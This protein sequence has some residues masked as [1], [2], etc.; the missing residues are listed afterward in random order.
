MLEQSVR[1]ALIFLA[2]A[3]SVAFTIRQNRTSL[4]KIVILRF[5]LPFALFLSLV[6]PITYQSVA[7]SFRRFRRKLPASPVAR[8]AAVFGIPASLGFTA[9]QLYRTPLA[10]VAG[11]LA[12]MPVMLWHF[13]VRISKLACP[14]TLAS[15]IRACAAFLIGI[16]LATGFVVG[17]N[18][19]V[20]R[21]MINAHAVAYKESPLDKSLPWHAPAPLPVA[22]ANP[23][24]KRSAL[25][26]QPTSRETASAPM[27]APSALFDL[28]DATLNPVQPATTTSR[29]GAR[30]FVNPEDDQFLADLG[31]N[32]QPW[33]KQ[34]SRPEGQS[35]FDFLIVPD[36]ASPYVGFV[37]LNSRSPATR[38]LGVG[39]LINSRI[40][41]AESFDITNDANP[42]V[43]PHDYLLNSEGTLLLHINGLAVEMISTA[44][45]RKDNFPLTVPD[46]APGDK[47]LPQLAGMTRDHG[48]LVRWSS[49]TATEQIV[50]RY[51]YTTRQLTDTSEVHDA[52]LATESSAVSVS[53]TGPIWLASIVAPMQRPL[54]ICLIN[55]GNSHGAFNSAAMPAAVRD[56]SDYEHVELA[57]SPDASQFGLLLT[58]RSQAVVYIWKSNDLSAT[59]LKVTPPMLSPA[60]ASS[61]VAGPRIRWIDNLAAPG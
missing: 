25:Q 15:Y 60:L 27:P 2:I 26:G 49:A 24:G 8:V 11:L 16:A 17:I 39:L 53:P 59:P 47:L 12:S 44:T 45:H 23:E 6:L 19:V 37:T 52:L 4:P 13:L 20:N 31:K 46:R 29:A 42:H 56:L 48:V 51:S 58:D 33:I 57:F 35:P 3:L 22:I 41:R 55:V 38:R 30:L 50:Q 21:A 9:W 14:E 61:H 18:F 7:A 28:S 1:R 54:S 34:V 32:A 10:L 40:R 36:E 43:F 5:A